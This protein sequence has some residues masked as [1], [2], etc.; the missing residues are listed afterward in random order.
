[1]WSG[2]SRFDYTMLDLFSSGNGVIGVD[3]PTRLNSF[4][5]KLAPEMPITPDEII[6]NHTL[7]PLHKPFI[8]PK[9]S[10][11]MSEIM[12]SAN[13]S[14]EKLALVGT[15]A[16]TVKPPRFFRYC[17]ECLEEDERSYGESYLHR[18]HQ[19]G[20]V[21]VCYK[22]GTW[23]QNSVFSVVTAE[24]NRSFTK[25][26]KKGLIGVTATMRDAPSKQLH[27]VS[28]SVWWLL[29]HEVPV[30]DQASL[31]ERY[32]H[33][34]KQE[35]LVRWN[36]QIL[37]KQLVNEFNEYFG[38]EFM[39]DTCLKLHHRAPS[40]RWL[41]DWLE[42][43]KVRMMHPVRHTFLQ[44]FLGLTEGAFWRNSMKKDDAFGARLRP[45]LNPTVSHYLKPVATLSFVFVS[46]ENGRWRCKVTCEK[47]GFS[48]I[49]YGGDAPRP[50]RCK[51]YVI[52]SYGG[53]WI[54]AF[55][56]LS[57]CR[58]MTANKIGKI[59]GISYRT[60]KRH[61]MMLKKE[62]PKEFRKV[63]IDLFGRRRS[64]Y[65]ARL[66]KHL[67]NNHDVSRKD[68]RRVLDTEYDWLM[69]YDLA[70]LDKQRPPVKKHFRWY[71]KD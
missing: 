6:Q 2:N 26:S 65:R 11:L 57:R 24:R 59:L 29:N 62:G 55:L 21:L 38:S 3:F 54:K 42:G 49:E 68:L 35:G 9:T 43:K 33:Y 23:L 67:R 39:K 32:I 70:W 45:C 53:A 5:E 30:F 41:F 37:R 58:K 71:R 47:C 12:K 18:S 52:V 22:H 61:L 63:L 8:L 17:P 48:Y 20:G 27:S 36:G 31:R 25:M 46:K 28:R 34:L 14:R 56:R 66:I 4:C 7:L 40:R 64:E 1:M 10:L 15:L 50:R 44:T 16:T 69:R 51:K 19:I 13:R 60:V